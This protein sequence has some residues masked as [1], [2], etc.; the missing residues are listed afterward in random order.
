MPFLI[1]YPVRAELVEAL[2][3]LLLLGGEEVQPFDKLRANGV[4]SNDLYQAN[5]FANWSSALFSPSVVSLE[6]SRF[7]RMSSSSAPCCERISAS[8]AAS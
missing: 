4:G 7:V 3:F 2:S 6:M 5:V 8:I 1:H